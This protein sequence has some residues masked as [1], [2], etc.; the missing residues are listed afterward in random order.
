MGISGSVQALGIFLTAKDLVL[1]GS[2][3]NKKANSLILRNRCPRAIR[4]LCQVS[5]STFF[6][7]LAPINHRAT[8]PLLKMVLLTHNKQKPLGFKTRLISLIIS[9]IS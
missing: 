7:L 4:P 6:N 5:K 1:A 9:I 2:F 8:L 3:C